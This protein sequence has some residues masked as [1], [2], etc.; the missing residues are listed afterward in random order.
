MT[1]EEFL[2]CVTAVRMYMKDRVNMQTD[3][4]R[5]VSYWKKASRMRV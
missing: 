2:A 1:H 4:I 3:M 5:G